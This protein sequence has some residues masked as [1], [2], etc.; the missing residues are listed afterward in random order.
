MP[1]SNPS[2]SWFSAVAGISL[3]LLG[4]ALVARG[5]DSAAKGQ[6]GEPRTKSAAG[7]VRLYDKSRDDQSQKA[8]TLSEGIASGQLFNK[9][10][11]NLTAL[12]AYSLDR[13]F[14]SAHRQ[15][16]ADLD[17]LFT[18]SDVA[19]LAEN[20][21]RTVRGG[22]LAGP[23][24]SAAAKTKLEAVQND[25]KDASEAVQ[26]ARDEKKDPRVIQFLERVG[27][28]GAVFN[29]ADSLRGKV[30][31]SKAD[32]LTAQEAVGLLGRLA[33]V[34]R[35]FQTATASA[36]TAADAVHEAKVK[37]LQAEAE[38]LHN[39]IQIS[40]R[41]EAELSDALQI[42]ASLKAGLEC[43]EHGR[44]QP[45]AD[46]P[47]RSDRAFKPDEQIEV[48]LRRVLQTA[49]GARQRADENQDAAAQARLEDEAWREKQIVATLLYSLYNASAIA[50]HGET[51]VRLADLRAAQEEHRYAI[52]Q[53]A[54][55]AHS[56]E[57]VIASGVQRLALYYKGGVKPE[58][59]AQI[60][61]ALATVGLIPTV[62][63]K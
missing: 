31:V 25:L 59:I 26:K 36:P 11:N 56:Y 12:S 63:L 39:V 35:D 55:L 62:A 48:S 15:M 52:R 10:L 3:V 6:S 28:P 14:T 38:H 30:G 24:E 37:L 43:I 23:A 2:N 8:L 45:D 41:R 60:V 49:K 58:V 34:Y 4:S 54:I 27:D 44:A 40:A 33:Q 18:W 20:F 21:E 19:A 57:T 51:P 53:N 29:F 46:C 42:A 9:Q 1:V 47:I 17:V 16:M 22:G 32:L 61:Q 7:G 5:Q 13:V 50:S